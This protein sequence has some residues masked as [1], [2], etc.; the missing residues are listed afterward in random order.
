MSDSP[1]PRSVAAE[2]SSGYNQRYTVAGQLRKIRPDGNLGWDMPRALKSIFVPPEEVEEGDLPDVE[3]CPNSTKW[4]C[5]RIGCKMYKQPREYADHKCLLSALLTHAIH[6]Y[7]AVRRH[8]LQAHEK[9]P[10]KK[11]FPFHCDACGRGVNGPA[12]LRRH[13]RTHIPIQLRTDWAYNCAQESCGYR[14]D[15]RH[16]WQDHVKWHERATAGEGS[17]ENIFFTAL[18]KAGIQCSRHKPFHKT[19]TAV[20]LHTARAEDVHAGHMIC[21][22]DGVV[23]SCTNPDGSTSYVPETTDLITESD[24]LAHKRNGSYYCIREESSRAFKIWGAT[25]RT[26]ILVRV[27]NHETSYHGPDA[28]TVPLKI[29]AQRTAAILREIIATEIDRVAKGIE[30]DPVSLYYIYY[31]TYQDDYRLR[32]ADHSDFY[33]PA[34]DCIK[35]VYNKPEPET[36][37]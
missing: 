34:K 7:F 19:A 35:L 11:A 9:D 32:V 36:A 1:L 28:V 17:L 15:A 30:A 29:K 37:K 6:S 12:P 16:A 33:R 13:M 8:A 21:Y 23:L 2:Y 5:V 18:A 3:Q 27:I 25:R 4:Q 10:F 22:V 24:E 14:T 26:T 31:D 20:E